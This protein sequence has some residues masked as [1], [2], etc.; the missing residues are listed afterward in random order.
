M[1]G[2]ERPRGRVFVREAL[3]IGEFL[4]ETLW[5]VGE[6]VLLLAALGA[7]GV[8]VFLVAMRLFWKE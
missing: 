1:R 7:L 4:I 3:T 5:L 6:A 8:G 2:S